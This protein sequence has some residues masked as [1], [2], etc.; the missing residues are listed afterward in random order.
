MSDPKRWLQELGKNSDSQGDL[1]V[2]MLRAGRDERPRS[3]GGGK[4]AVLAALGVSTATATLSA[5]ATAATVA[6]ASLVPAALVATAGSAGALGLK[7]LAVGLAVVVA[8]VGGTAYVRAQHGAPVESDAERVPAVVSTPSA[9]SPVETNEG[10]FMAPAT[11]IPATATPPAAKTSVLRAPMSQPFS[12][13][14]LPVVASEPSSESPSSEVPAAAEPS[15]VAVELAALQ[16]ARA[17]AEARDHA[18][19]LKLANDYEASGRRM[20][21]AEMQVLAIDALVA[22][23]ALG[24]AKW[25]VNR[26]L[27]DHPN[28]PMAE[29]VRPVLGR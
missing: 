7:A 21:A 22:Q 17:R 28:G 10:A 6:T 19:V 3:G 1:L 5:S 16:E 13:P 14:A 4:S 18:A 23:G 8:G 20:F 25:R 9:P 15:A 27:V 26:F 29:H 2:D 12:S 11:A 24:Q